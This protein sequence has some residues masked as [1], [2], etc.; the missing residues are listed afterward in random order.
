[1]DITTKCYQVKDKEVKAQT[2]G[3]VVYLPQSWTGKKVRVLLLEPINEWLL[4][5]TCSS[6][7]DRWT[8]IICSQS[9]QLYRTML[10]QK[11]IAPDHDELERA[12]NNTKLSPLKKKIV[13]EMVMKYDSAL[14][15]LSQW[16]FDITLF[17]TIQYLTFSSSILYFA[18]SSTNF[19][20]SVSDAVRDR[21]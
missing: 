1:M 5:V 19:A 14:D 7:M 6:E 8:K 9:V 12:L 18:N 17:L 20:D 10:K 3:G 13:R 2:S 11:E 15:V 16:D 4:R 21:F